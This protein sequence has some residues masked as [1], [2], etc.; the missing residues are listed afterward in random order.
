MLTSGLQETQ[1]RRIEFVDVNEEVA[2][3]FLAF[4][5][6]MDFMPVNFMREDMSFELL[7]LAHKYNVSSLE[8]LMIKT[9]LLVPNDGFNW[10][11]ALSLYFFSRNIE[12]LQIVC[13]KMLNIMRKYVSSDL[14]FLKLDY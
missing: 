11:V 10:D 13:D 3:Q 12:A 8:T 4:I 9:L 2:T 5:Y 14:Q 1:T 6:G 7:R